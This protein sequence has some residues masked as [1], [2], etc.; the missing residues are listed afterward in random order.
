MSKEFWFNLPVKDVQK[1]KAFFKAIGF[2]SNPIH[3]SNNHLGSFFIG[4]K[5]VVMMIFPD[6]TFK[7]FTSNNISDTD[8][9]TE[10]LFN[11]DAQNRAEVDEMA[12]TVK[13]AGRTIY[14]EPGEKD[15]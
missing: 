9:A 4:E 10:V 8:K 13:S 3:D 7:S 5:K 1:S 15:G 11:I 6:E 14:A 12:K 2:I